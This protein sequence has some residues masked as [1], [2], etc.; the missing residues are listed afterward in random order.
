MRSEAAPAWRGL[1][2]AA[3]LAGMTPAQEGGMSIKDVPEASRDTAADSGS[4][5]SIRD[6][7]GQGAQLGHTNIETKP[8]TQFLDESFVQLVPYKHIRN[9]ESG[10]DF[11]ANTA[12]PYLFE[13]R[14]APHIFLFENISTVL[15]TQ[16]PFSFKGEDRRVS[17][18]LA[19]TPEVGIRMLSTNSVPV[20]RPSFRPYLSL[21]RTVYQR[22]SV[23]DPKVRIWNL[24]FIAI[25]YS[26]GAE[27][28][29]FH[30]QVRT[31][32]E[33]GDHFPESDCS[34]IDQDSLAFYRINTLDGEYS[35]T[36]FIGGIDFKRIWLDGEGYEYRH[37]RGSLDVEYHPDWP[38]LF[39]VE[40][41]TQRRIY[42]RDWMTS[43]KLG[44]GD[45]F[46]KIHQQEVYLRGD[47]FPGVMLETNDEISGAWV[48]PFSL[49]ATYAIY[50]GWKSILRG[51]GFYVKYNEGQDKHNVEFRHYIR[52]VSLG[53]I[54][55]SIYRFRMN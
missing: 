48:P 41:D 24:R 35:S 32:G 49:E 43:L 15:L 14:V 3:L 44:W 30:H 42:N 19:F 22:N 12:F 34:D 51:W 45:R 5:A 38:W 17:Y 29:R 40:S 31:V 1:L 33:N 53:L 50:P 16:R 4:G 46:R 54:S 10:N 13:A 27:G 20:R 2:A 6:H 36:F 21:D 18:D 26:D 52:Q 39:G 47:L 9:E 28:C 37:L 25:H 23:T 55:R 7:E 11:T 8:Y